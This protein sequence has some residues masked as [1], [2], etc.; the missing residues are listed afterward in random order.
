MSLMRMPRVVRLRLEQI[1]RDFLWGGGALE[2]KSYLVKY[3]IVYSDKKG[4]LGVRN[5][6]TLNRALLCKWNWRFVVEIESLWRLVISRKFGVEEGGWCTREVREGYGVGLWKEIRKEGSRMFKNIVFS[7]GD[8][9]RVRFWK[10]KCYGDNPSA[11][12]FLLCM[13]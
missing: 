2:K 3:A 7:I 9:R 8:G 4:G 10:D 12:I 5:L 11:I 13:I 6:S 1:Q